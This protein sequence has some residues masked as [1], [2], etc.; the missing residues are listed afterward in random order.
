MRKPFIFAFLANVILSLC[1]VTVLPERTAIHFGFG[2][3]PD[4]W[5][6]PGE[7][8][9]LMSVTDAV[10]FLTFLFSAKLTH[11]LPARFINLPNR[12][13]W[14]NEKNRSKAEAMLTE[15]MYLFGTATYVFMFLITLLVL[16]A[17]LSSPVRLQETP[18][19]WAFGLYIGFTVYWT[20]R[21]YRRFRVPA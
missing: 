18:L 20:V 2:G 3:L 1:S 7:F 5:A 11:R 17:N 14:L 12:A 21:L 4:N 8:A 19:W 16:R 6:A 9:L 13:Y 15:E 10:I